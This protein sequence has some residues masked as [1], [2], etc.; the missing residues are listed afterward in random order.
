MNN[1]DNFVSLLSDEI[2]SFTVRSSMFKLDVNGTVGQVGMT[3][4]FNSYSVVSDVDVEGSFSCT[5]NVAGISFYGSHLSVSGYR[6]KMHDVST[7]TFSGVT[8]FQYGRVD[9]SDAVAEFS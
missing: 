8:C 2:S 6:L 4:Q 5:G 3:Q 1:K 9:I 7:G